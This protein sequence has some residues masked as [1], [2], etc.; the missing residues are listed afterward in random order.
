[1]VGPILPDVKR[2][3]LTYEISD[4]FESLVEF[5][6]AFTFFFACVFFLASVPIVGIGQTKVVANNVSHKS[7]NE[8]MTSLLGCFGPCFVATVET[9]ENA[10]LDD[11]TS[12]KL[13]ASPGIAVGLASYIGE[14]ELQFP[15]S[16]PANQWTYVRIGTTDPGLLNVLLGGL[17]G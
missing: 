17:F 6:L 12:A 2:K 7:G 10:T 16:I 5:Y 8:K 13:L 14:I 3:E 1:M 11:N 9:P 15:N 4:R